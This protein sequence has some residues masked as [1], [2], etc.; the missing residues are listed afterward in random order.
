MKNTF[1]DIPDFP[2]KKYFPMARNLMTTLYESGW[3]YLKMALTETVY[4]FQDI[5]NIRLDD[6]IQTSKL[7][8]DGKLGIPPE[9][10]FTFSLFVP[11]LGIRSDLQQGTNV[12]LFG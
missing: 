12:L 7:I 10:V 11:V 4:N 6:A 1:G 5:V 8:L 9:L 2:T 3:D